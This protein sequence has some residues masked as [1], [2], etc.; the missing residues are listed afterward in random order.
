MPNE[1]TQK[2]GAIRRV[3]VSMEGKPVGTLA[4]SAQGTIL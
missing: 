1:L 4:Q 3:D 2:L